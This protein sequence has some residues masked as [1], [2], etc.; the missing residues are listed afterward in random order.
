[1][2]EYVIKPLNRFKM[3]KMEIA[4][5]REP[6]LALKKYL[7]KKGIPYEMIN[8][9]TNEY[10]RINFSDVSPIEVCDKIDFEVS[11]HIYG[12]PSSD[13]CSMYIIK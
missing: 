8:R 13:N 11:E 2:K 3:H 5:A 7:Q 10:I 9:V 6:F 12:G 1:M 4:K